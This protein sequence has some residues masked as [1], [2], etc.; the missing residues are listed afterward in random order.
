M[1][2]RFVELSDEVRLL[3]HSMAQLADA[4][5]DERAVN[6]PMRAVLEYLDRNGD[7]TV[8]RM[9]QARRVSRQHIQVIVNDLADAGLV[10][11]HDNPAHQRSR[12]VGLTPSGRTSIDEMLKTERRLLEDALVD[13][14]ETDLTAAHD[15]LRSLRHRLDELADT[16]ESP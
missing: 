12:L 4:V 8:P 10:A 7:A 14:H 2:T 15:T 13:L 1:W 3:F 6:A 16:L 9:A 11:L 5:H